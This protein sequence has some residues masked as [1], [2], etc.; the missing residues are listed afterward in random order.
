[1]YGVQ[2]RVECELRREGFEGMADAGVRGILDSAGLQPSDDP[3][4]AMGYAALPD[5]EAGEL[6][7]YHVTDDPGRVR[8]RLAQCAPL[9]EGRSGGDLGPGLYCSAA[10][11]V[12]TGRSRAKWEFLY[13]LTPEERRRLGESLR[14]QLEEDRRRQRISGDELQHGLRDLDRWEQGVYGPAAIVSLAEPPYSIPFW[15]P[16]YL[17]RLG[18]RPG[19]QP[20]VVEMRVR[21]RFAELGWYPGARVT[22]ALRRA[23]LQGAYTSAG[24]GT[25]PQLVVWDDAAVR[26][27]DG[28]RPDCPPAWEAS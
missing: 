18:I 1:M 2:A 25:D 27:F 6:I 20:E 22:E 26:E 8:S 13:R 28:I 17:A 16:D 12:W 7:C 4:R 11:Q 21:G 3:Y 23:G 15:R 5:P 24:F 9:T 14:A 19:R 10:P